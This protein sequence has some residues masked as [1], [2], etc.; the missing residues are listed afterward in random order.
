MA[1]AQQTNNQFVTVNNTLVINNI[2]VT[3]SNVILVLRGVSLQ[4]EPGQ[5]VSLLGPNGAGK[6]TTLKAVSGLLKSETGEVTRGN[7]TWG[8]LRLDTL[9][10]EEIVRH[11]VIQVIE[12]RPLF[13]H[14]T[15]EENLRVGSMT[16]EG[17]SHYRNDID[18]VYH[19][20]PRLKEMHRRV[21]GYLSGGE[22]QMLVI[23]RALMGHPKLLMLDEPS[24][25]LAP[26]LV[27]EIFDIIRDINDRE[28]MSLLIV[29]Q[30]A[31]VALQIADYGYVMENG[32]IVLD[33]PAKQL[34]ENEDI[35][36]FYLGLNQ[37]GE[38]KSYRD[39]K[40][41]KRRKR[42]LG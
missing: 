31:R 14:L 6:S 9:T 42:W 12:G 22:A 19:Y 27:E 5:I 33:G 35:K 13:Q 38:R 37:M 41:Y 4:V 10:A 32:R 18:R 39:V 34:R 2:E 30:N 7:I 26:M 24:L 20:F 21:S 40:H 11:Q 36:E 23:G 25:G 17:G 8:D 3:Y 29:E 1:E 16:Y 28:G 15:V